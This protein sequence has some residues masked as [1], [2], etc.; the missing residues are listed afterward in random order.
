LTAQIEPMEDK[1]YY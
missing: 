1:K